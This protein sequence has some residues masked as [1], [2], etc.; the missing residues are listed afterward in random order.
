MKMASPERDYTFT[1][2]SPFY[3]AYFGQAA[4]PISPDELIY[5][6]NSV[7]N[8]CTVYNPLK[9]TYSTIYETSSFSGVDPYDVFL[10]GAESI[11]VIENPNN[12]QGDELYIF[13]DSFTSALSP[14][15]IESCSKIVLIDPR[16]IAPENVAKYIEL[17]ENS[18]VLFMFSTTILNKGYLFK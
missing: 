9:N 8:N 1:T 12:P 18:K 17:S 6:S 4:L 16:Y 5:L 11:L 15:L 10:S 2:L 14:L 7:L 3:G 13:R